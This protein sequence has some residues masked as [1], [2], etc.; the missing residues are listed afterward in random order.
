[1]TDSVTWDNTCRLLSR[2]A[3]ESE[4]AAMPGDAHMLRDAAAHLSASPTGSRL[5][6]ALDS[7]PEDAR[8]GIF[9]RPPERCGW[10]GRISYVSD[11]FLGRLPREVA[12]ALGLQSG[13][14][15]CFHLVEVGDQHG[16]DGK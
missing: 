8:V 1:M 12:T 11:R 10:E 9:D 16:E 5:W 7:V 13:D 6:I 2:L 15:K 14:C 4:M 3:E